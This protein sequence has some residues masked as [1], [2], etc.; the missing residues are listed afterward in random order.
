MRDL[1]RQLKLDEEEFRWQD[2]SLCANAETEWFF[3]VF[4]DDP[5]VASQIRSMC[6]A[7]PV[8]SECLLD[9]IETKSYGVRGG[10]HMDGRGRLSENCNDPAMVKT[11]NEGIEEL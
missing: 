9:G 10:F 3:D 2:L 5:E 4:E 8:K 11:I 6:A 1:L 7:C